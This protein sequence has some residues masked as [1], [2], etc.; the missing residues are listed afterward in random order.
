METPELDPVRSEL[1]AGRMIDTL[2]GAALALMISIGHQTG[3]FDTL[4]GLPPSSSNGI[5]EAAGLNERYVR[6]WLGAMVTGR[7][8]EHD[9]DMGTYWLPPEHAASLTRAAGANNLAIQAQY[10]PLLAG[11]EAPIVECFRH[12][13]GVPY[14]AYPRFQALMAEDSSKVQD[15]TLVDH[16]LSRVPGLIDRLEAGI[17]VL[18][19]GCGQGHAVNLMAMAFPRTRVTGFDLSPEA[20]AAGRA[21]AEAWGLA[22]AH[23]EVRDVAN[24]GV[25]SRYDL[26]TAF[27][28]IH[29]QAQP[30]AVLKGVA[31]ALRP[32]GQFLM[33]DIR[34]SSHHHENLDHPLAPFLYTI[35]CMHCMTVSL[36]LGGAG[37]GA[38][39]GEE[40]A[41]E[42][43]ADAGFTRIWV[44]HVE[45]DRL[46][47]YYV[48]TRN[49]PRRLTPRPGG[50]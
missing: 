16:V 1:F 6:E 3:L 20:V 24:L 23:H 19:V 25:E 46:N 22:N 12:G 34:G 50:A 32:G 30:A 15:A 49:E 45:E 33:V 41:R 47:T 26:I 35:S 5:A 39:W 11:V 42:M 43:L 48:A 7:I 27:D 44:H 29:D 2:N 21:E 10:I 37:L 28:A 14:E 38:M 40:K 4:A 17:E 8:V 18:D 13:G 9:P 31:T 36:A